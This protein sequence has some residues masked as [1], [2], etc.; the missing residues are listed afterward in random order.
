MSLE[1][2]DIEALDTGQYQ[3]MVI[4]DPNDKRNIRGFFHLAQVYSVTMRN[5]DYHQG[6]ARRLAALTRLVDVMNKWTQVKTDLIGTYTFDDEEMLKTPW[7][8]AQ[9]TSAFQ[10][11]ASE[12]RSLG[13]YLLYGGFMVGDGSTVPNTPRDIS[14]REMFKDG[15]A[16]QGWRYGQDWNFERLPNNHAIYHCYFD[17]NDGPPLA[18][19]WTSTKPNPGS[20]KIGGIH[21]LESIEIHNRLVALMCNKW[22][23]NA[24]GDWGDPANTWGHQGTLYKTLDPTRPL[25]FG[26]NLI[27]FALTQEG[28][29]TNRVMDAVR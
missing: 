29:I 27:I 23:A 20:P 9:A 18:G 26:V 21:Y 19:D 6:I 3:A 28:S 4:Q 10:V 15:L 24:W 16:T 22:F 8:Y 12:A 1:M 5:R 14:V 25:Q 11:T 17:F 7:I 2:L 13:Q